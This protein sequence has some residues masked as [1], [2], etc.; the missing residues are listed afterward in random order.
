M[1][2]LSYLMYSGKCPLCKKGALEL[3]WLL[4]WQKKEKR[5]EKLLCYAF[6]GS[7]GEK[8]RRAFENIEV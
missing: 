2:G 3:E 5:F 4:G 6:L 7:L 1:G 8:N